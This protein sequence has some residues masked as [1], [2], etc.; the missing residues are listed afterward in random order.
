[1]LAELTVTAPVPLDVSVT[2]CV[3]LD[4]TATLPKLRLL[5]FTVS[6]G[7][8]VPVPL[9]LT[10]AVGFVDEVLLMVNVPVTAPAVFGAN[11]TVSAT[12]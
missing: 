5:V 2:V 4:P 6:F 11:F 3:G 9:R 8:V 7:D 12:D 10:V 1:M